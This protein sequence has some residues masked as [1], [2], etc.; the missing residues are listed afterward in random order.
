M[1]YGGLSGMSLPQ[2]L[3]QNSKV[4]IRQSYVPVLFLHLVKPLVADGSDAA[5]DV[6]ERMDE[7][8]LTRED[9]D[10]IVELGVDEDKDDV[11]KRIPAATKTAFTKWYNAGEHPFAFHKA[12]DLGR[13]P[14]RIPGGTVPDIEEAFEVHVV[15]SFSAFR[16]DAILM[17]ACAAVGRRVGVT[18]LIH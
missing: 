18:T 10:T 17:Y 1:G 12:V 5:D 8:N 15:H 6:I 14:K 4:E 16:V 7:Y 3:G 9:W 13:A 2:W 11:L